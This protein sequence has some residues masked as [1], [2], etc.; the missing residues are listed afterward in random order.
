MFRKNGPKSWFSSALLIA[1]TCGFCSPSDQIDLRNAHPAVFQHLTIQNQ[2]DYGV[3]YA[4]AGSALLDYFR[5]LNHTDQANTLR[6]NPVYAAQRTAM[7]TS[8]EDAEGGNICD[9]INTLVSEKTACADY[10]VSGNQIRGFGDLAQTE[11]M[12]DVYLPYLNGV[13][14]FL[15]VPPASFVYSKRANLT[16]GQKEYL[17]KFDDYLSW[18]KVALAD[19]G[20]SYADIPSDTDIFAFIQKTYVSRN[21]STFTVT[22]ENWLTS[23]SCRSSSFKVPALTCKHYTAKTS[24]SVST[25]L[26]DHTLLEEQKPVGIDFCANVLTNSRY[27]GLANGQPRGDCGEH[28]VMVIG[29]KYDSGQCY[30]LI[31]NSWGAAYS[32]YAWNTSRGDVWVEENALSANLFGLSL[33]R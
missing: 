3:C 2:G 25:Y 26:L 32:S 12:N 33:V 6:T 15:A 24:P 14:P 30:Y 27:Q 17:N 9:V 5:L 23:A 21:F 18:V 13:K 7:A 11:L 1:A 4:Y 22:F 10:R 8:A 19:R 31:R 28:A 16:P 29:K 20:I